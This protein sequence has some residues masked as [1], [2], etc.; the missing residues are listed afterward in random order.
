MEYFP[1]FEMLDAKI[2]SALNKIIL[3]SEFKK[4]VSLEEQKAQKEDR[5]LRGRQIAFIVYDYFRLTGAHDTVLDCA[6]FFSVTVRDDH[7]EGFDTRWDEVLL[8]ETLTPG[9]GELKQEQCSRI[10]RKQVALKEEKVSVNSGKKKGQRSKGDRCSF[11]HESSDRAQKPERHTSRAINDTRSSVSKKRS[12]QGKRNHGAIL[13]QLYRYYLKGTYTRSSCEYWHP[14]GCQFYKTETGC[15]AGDKCLFPHHAVD[16]RPNK[17]KERLLFTRKKWKR[18]QECSGYCDNC[19]TT[20]LPVARLGSILVSQSGKPPRRNPMQKVLGSIRKVRSTL[21][22]ASIRE[23]KGPSLGKIQVQNPHQR[24]PY[25]M[26]FEDRSQ[27]ETERQQRCARSKAWNLAN[28]I[29]HKLKEKDKATFHSPAEEWVL[30]GASAREPEEREFAVDS[31][32]IMHMVSKRDL[33][34]AELETMRTSRSPTT[35]MTANGEEQTR[36]EATVHVKP[37]DL[38]VTVLLLQEPPAVL[39][40]WKLCEDHGYTSH[41]ISSQKAHLTRN[42]KRIDC[43]ISNYVPF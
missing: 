33:N 8:F 43:N 6:D 40:W 28:N 41:W 18:R 39:S 37:L 14:P 13:R 9:T 34:S 31:G 7:I 17:T 22:Q 21:R 29:Q 42:G 26:K 3:N 5:F 19:A 25:A 1:N 20:G 12:I 16:E 32:A 30:P 36:E 38:F 11:R 4:K 2:A 10:E 35:M 15:K 27:G 24:S 23:K